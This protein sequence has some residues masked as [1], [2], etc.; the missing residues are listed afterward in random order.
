MDSYYCWLQNFLFILRTSIKFLPIEGIIILF[1]LS[2]NMLQVLDFEFSVFHP[3]NNFVGCVII[4]ISYARYFK[5]Q[6]DI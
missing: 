4:G 6:L 2:I 3:N 1:Y 5:F